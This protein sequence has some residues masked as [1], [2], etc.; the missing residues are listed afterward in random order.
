MNQKDDATR[1]QRQVM[2]PEVGTEGQ[3][4]LQAARIFIVGSGGLASSSAYYLAAAG[5]G[6]IGIADDDQVDLSN[7]NRQ[8]L[9][10]TSRI[11]M[12]KVDSAQKTLQALHPALDVEALSHRLS[13]CE[14]LMAAFADYD[15]VV[16]CTDNYATRYNINEACIRT[17]TPWI[18]G[19][20]SGFEGQAMTIVPGQGPCYKCLYPS[21]PLDTD[22][23]VPVMGV[24]PGI[25]G[26]IEAAEAIKHILG[27]GVPLLGRM[28]FIDLFDM[29]ISE[30]KINRNPNCPA[31]GQ[32]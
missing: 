15:L 2:M 29:A 18:Y 12:A 26:I 9:H 10:N 4:K 32:L 7:L 21:A 1:F 31:C 13:T 3:K 27:V 28:L 17:R 20:I 30:F 14:E 16:D 25:I 5:I 19:A 22:V 11:G 8:I 24:T 23:A 6:K